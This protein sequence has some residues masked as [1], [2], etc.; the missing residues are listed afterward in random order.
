M[1]PARLASLCAVLNLNETD[2]SRITGYTRG[3]VRN[4]TSGKSAVWPPFAAWLETVAPPVQA[5]LAKHPAPNRHRPEV[6]R[7]VPNLVAEV[8]RSLPPPGAEPRE[9][10]Q[11]AIAAERAARQPAEVR[12]DAVDYASARLAPVLG[13]E[14]YCGRC[15]RTFRTARCVCEAAA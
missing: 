13:P 10:R 11:A 6:P 15:G 8:L 14:T 2:V 5:I 9:V 7:V 4:W 3:A 12:P 1:T